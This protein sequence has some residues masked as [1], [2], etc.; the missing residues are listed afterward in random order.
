MRV[1]LAILS[2]LLVLTAQVQPERPRSH[3][4][5]SVGGQPASV[6]VRYGI[7]AEG[8]REELRVLGTPQRGSAPGGI[9]F[10]SDTPP[11]PAARAPRR[12]PAYHP[13]RPRA[14]PRALDSDSVH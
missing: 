8:V 2:A 4:T 12:A 11:S 14:R 10:V 3:R 5:A 13:R 7:E 9:V 1:A 6:A